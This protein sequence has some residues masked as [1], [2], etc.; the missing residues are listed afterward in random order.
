MNRGSLAV[1]KYSSIG[2]E[3]KIAPPFNAGTHG[4]LSSIFFTLFASKESIPLKSSNC[5][6][7]FT[8]HLQPTFLLSSCLALSLH[9]SGYCWQSAAAQLETRGRAAE[10]D[11][12][13]STDGLR[14]D[15][16]S[17]RQA[18]SATSFFK[19]STVTK[20][21]CWHCLF[22][23]TTDMLKFSHFFS[24]Q[25]RGS[26]LVR[27]RQKKTQYVSMHSYVKPWLKLD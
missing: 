5:G 24:L 9:S 6:L 22:L 20:N 10:V 13:D 26:F 16:T 11:C 3:G 18:Q 21:Y 4:S 7:F 2:S 12:N 27:L 14:G 19:S 8:H 25:L 15:F 1:L 17:L 23:Q